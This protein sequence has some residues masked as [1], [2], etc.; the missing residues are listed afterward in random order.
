MND[1]TPP[2]P[3][4]INLTEAQIAAITGAGGTCS[5]EEWVAI[6]GQLK[7]AYDNIVDFTSYVFERVI[8][9]Q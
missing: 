8:G 2:V 6:T 9:P 7:E 4:G 1:Q 5:A 3:A